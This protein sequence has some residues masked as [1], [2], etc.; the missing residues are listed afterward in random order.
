M[1]LRPAYS[2]TYLGHTNY[3][4]LYR[5][6]AYIL[7]VSRVRALTMPYGRHPSTTMSY[8]ANLRIGHSSGRV[9][10]LV[11]LYRSST[12]MNQ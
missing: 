7:T 2:F 8:H 3:C 10:P 12:P 9:G 5:T 11:R 6:S 1:N 4:G